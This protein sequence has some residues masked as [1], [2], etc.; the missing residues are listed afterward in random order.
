[1][2]SLL[3]LLLLLLRRQNRPAVRSVLEPV[4]ATLC[5][6]KLDKLLFLLSCMSCLDTV[7]RLVN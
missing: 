4:L 7:G 6:L 3:L 2:Q 1:M 5:C